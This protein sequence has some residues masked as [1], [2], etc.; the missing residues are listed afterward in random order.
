MLQKR[1]LLKL[2]GHTDWIGSDAANQRLAKERAE[3]VKKYLVSQG[4]GSVHIEAVG[5]GESQPVATNKTADGRQK[6]R[7]VAFTL[8]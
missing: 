2:A 6:N 3:S 1:V 8:F 7:R 4:A 5:Y